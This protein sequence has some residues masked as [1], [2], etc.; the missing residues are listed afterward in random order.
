MKSVFRFALVL[1]VLCVS[2]LPTWAGVIYSNLG[3]SNPPYDENS[4]WAVFNGAGQQAVGMVFTAGS[5]GSV[6]QIDVAL[7]LTFSNGNA[8]VSLWTDSGGL[9]GTSLG[10]WNV[11]VTEPFG[12]YSG[13]VVTIPGLAGPSLTADETYILAVI[14]D[15]TTTNDLGWYYNNQGLSGPFVYSTDGGSTWGAT[16]GPLSAFDILGGPASAP[17]PTTVALLGAGLLCLLARARKRALR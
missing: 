7:G 13:A 4:G 3:A 1:A 8:T 12:D 14:A 2:S 15:P 16:S 10:S 5:S 17:E 11:T 6:S 9:P